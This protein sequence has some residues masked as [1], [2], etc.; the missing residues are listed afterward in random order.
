MDQNKEKALLN[1]LKKEY[2]KIEP[3]DE[4]GSELEDKLVDKFSKKKTIF[5]YPIFG[6]IFTAG[7]FLILI[8]NWDSSNQNASKPAQETNII[9]K[10][11]TEE[12]IVGSKPVE[13]V[14]NDLK[15][16]L[17]MDNATTPT[18]F[19]IDDNT[20]LTGYIEENTSNS[21]KI[22]YYQIN[23]SR[24]INVDQLTRLDEELIATFSAKDYKEDSNSLEEDF[25]ENTDPINVE[26]GEET[27]LDLGFDIY[28]KYEEDKL[29]ESVN[30]QEGRWFLQVSSMI[31][32][33]MEIENIAI[34]IVEFLE[35]K[36]LPAPDVGNVFVAYDEGGNSVD[37]NI[38]W[39]NDNIVYQLETT[40]VPINAL[41]MVVSV[42]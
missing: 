17:V 23:D 12:E 38:I 26:P 27:A 10:E 16:L 37:V 3:R 7:L 20:F 35:K 19:P 1:L 2:N 34:Q 15:A 22:S 40:E 31:S 13:E 30:W 11:R 4:F 9:S 28:G 25:T 5:W 33:Q 36:L 21:Y 42:K 29:R 6:L 18:T 32:D 8:L 14:V 41:D 39:I 24:E